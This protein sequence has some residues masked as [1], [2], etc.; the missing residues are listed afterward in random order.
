MG[1]GR[2]N[3]W[4]LYPGNG[5]FSYLPP[6]ERP[7]YYMRY[8]MINGLIPPFT[9]GLTKEDRIS[10]LQTIKSNLEITKTNIE[11]QIQDINNIIEELKKS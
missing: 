10:Y 5:P 1:C 8:S 7:G 4:N 9:Y 11:K 2:N 3:M 6:W